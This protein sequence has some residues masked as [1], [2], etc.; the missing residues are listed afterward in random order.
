MQ[1]RLKLNNYSQ[2]QFMLEQ[3]FQQKNV[4]GTNGMMI[5]P[6]QSSKIISKLSGVP[7]G[8]HKQGNTVAC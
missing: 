2:T 1:S 5:Y 4:V 3:I 6:L 7:T 8:S